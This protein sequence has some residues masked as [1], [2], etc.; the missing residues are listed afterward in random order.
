LYHYAKAD[1]AE[2]FVDGPVCSFLGFLKPNAIRN[3][4]KARATAEEAA[5]AAASLR[6]AAAGGPGGAVVAAGIAFL[7]AV[8]A[9]A[10]VLGG[11]GDGDAAPKT[12]KEAKV[13]GCTS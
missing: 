7:V 1:S 5:A 8:G 11:G 4:E 2:E 12:P 13:G 9:A 10:V 3:A 6:R